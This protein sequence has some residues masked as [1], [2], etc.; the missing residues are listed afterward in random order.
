MSRDTQTIGR[1][2][3]ANIPGEPVAVSPQAVEAYESMLA[4]VPDAEG[5]GYDRILEQ[6]ASAT[7]PQALNSPW[8]SSG[9]EELL[10]RKLVV[11]SIAKMPSEVSRQLPWFLIAQCVDEDSGEAVT[12]TT[13]SITVVAQL[14]KLWQLQAYPVHVIPRQSE[15]PTKQG[16][17]AQRLE[18]IK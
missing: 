13:G 2:D 3:V 16:Y 18:I 10:G 11:L 8:E 14:A 1:E 7:T 15:R 9:L 12:F 4:Q 17:Y 5:S 6:L